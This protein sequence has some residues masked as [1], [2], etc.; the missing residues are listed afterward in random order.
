MMIMMALF[1]VMAVCC[2]VAVHMHPELI[3]S[4]KNWFSEMVKVPHL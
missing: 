4:V 2:L 1:L 3:G